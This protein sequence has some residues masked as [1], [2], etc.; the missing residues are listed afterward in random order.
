M[1]VLRATRGGKSVEY[2][3]TNG[4]VTVGTAR[5]CQI[6]VADP[7]GA[8]KHC[9][10]VKSPT[11]FVV[12]D[13]SGSPGT[14]VNGKKIQDHL[15]KQGDVIQIGAEKFV[16]AEGNPAPAAP[17]GRS[18]PARRLPTPARPATPGGTKAPGA[19]RPPSGPRKLTVKP[20]SI[21][22]VHKSHS[23]FVLP[24]TRKGRA[25]ALTVG[26]GLLALGGALFAVSANQVNSEDVKKRCR[27]EVEACLALPDTEVFKRF[28]NAQGI[29][30]SEDYRKYAPVELRPLEK[31]WPEIKSRADL[32]TRAG[33]EAKAFLDKFRDIKEGPPAEYEKRSQ[34]L[35]DQAKNLLE[36]FGTTTFGPRLTEVRNELMA[37]ID[38]HMTKPWTNEVVPLRRSVQKA[39][40]TGAFANALAIVDEFG[41]RFREGEDPNLKKLLQGERDKVQQLSKPYVEKLYAAEGTREEKR[42]ALVAARPGLKGCGE[43]EK[44]LEKYINELK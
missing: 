38:A 3:L 12:I 30:A 21:A 14:F 27:H 41:K 33:R 22:R 7:A 5:E 17:E 9:Q 36:D 35:Y 11:G 1:S 28:T 43:A 19:N 20:G 23:L 40:D 34:D 18:T 29:L 31:A 24:S 44:L 15:L 2:P 8:P 42:K 10:I 37:F 39:I 16:Y 6:V 13:R 26:V 32:E 4:G 25:I